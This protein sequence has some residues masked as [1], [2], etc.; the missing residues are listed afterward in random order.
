MIENTDRAP[1]AVLALCLGNICRSPIAEGLLRAHVDRVNLELHID[2]AG[3]SSYHSG[4]PPDSRSVQT[5]SKHGIEISH[6]RSRALTREDFDR[7]DLI[8]AMDQNNLR[9]ARKLAPSS[10]DAQKVK[11][12]LRDGREVPDPYYGGARGFEEVYLMIDSAAS[13]WVSAW[14]EGHLE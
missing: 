1:R 13:E 5:M 3:T 8:L 2:S 10:A 12:F 14:R 4:E 6:Q 9:D 7:F 11:L